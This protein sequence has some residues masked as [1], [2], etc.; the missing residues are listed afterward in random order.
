MNKI[1]DELELIKTDFA[2]REASRRIH[3]QNLGKFQNLK[4]PASRILSGDF[5]R[6]K[7]KVIADSIIKTYRICFS[8]IFKDEISL[9]SYRSA[10]DISCQKSVISG[11]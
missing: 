3:I 1:N 4:I 9:L 10:E 6:F 2:K 11:K 7:P 8:S 5:N